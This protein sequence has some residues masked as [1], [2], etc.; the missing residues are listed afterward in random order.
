MGSAAFH[1]SEILATKTVSSLFNDYNE[2]CVDIIQTLITLPL[3]SQ[4][5][6]NIHTSYEAFLREFSKIENEIGTSFY[7]LYILKGLVDVARIIRADY[8]QRESRQHA[9]DYF[10]SA[11]Y[12][13]LDSISKYNRPKDIQ[14]ETMLCSLYCLSRCIEGIL[15]HASH[16]RSREK[17]KQYQ[18]LP[19]KTIEEM[20]AIIDINIE[21]DYIF[22]DH[23]T[24][25]VLDAWE[26][27]SDILELQKEEWENMNTLS[28]IS[29]GSELYKIYL[30]NK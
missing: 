17:E 9:V 5:Y 1:V 19:L 27:H 15:Y 28:S 22:N 25:I 3:Q 4:E 2:Y 20:Y 24:V 18:Q 14:F 23:T 29:K 12:E 26:E 30:A 21:D 7:C 8:V 16:K 10:R 13:I 6:K 11:T